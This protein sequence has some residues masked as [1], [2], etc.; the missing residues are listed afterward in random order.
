M[1]PDDLLPPL[2]Y[3]FQKELSKAYSSAKSPLSNIFSMPQAGATMMDPMISIGDTYSEKLIGYMTGPEARQLEEILD[4]LDARLDW[5]TLTRMFTVVPKSPITEGHNTMLEKII[6]LYTAYM[7]HD[8]RSPIPHIAGPPGTNKSTVVEQLAEL[9]GK[10]L[11]IINVARI[12]V[13]ELEGVQ[14]PIGHADLPDDYRLKLLTST[15]WT[16]L[17]DGDVVLLDEFMRG[18]PEVYNGLLDI[19][20]S[21]QVAGFQIPQVFF[22]SASNSVAAYDPAL[23][24]RLLHIPVPDI[25]KNK[26]ARN[27]VKD[28]FIQKLGLNPAIRDLPELESLIAIEVQPMY[29]VLDQFSGKGARG[30]S[31]LK[32]QSIRKLIGQALLRE[33]QSPALKEVIEMNN[34]LSMKEGKAQFVLLPNGK[35]PP[36]GYE[37]KARALVGNDKL[38]QIQ[39]ENIELNLQLIEMEIASNETTTPEGDE[40]DDIF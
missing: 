1:N 24:D 22:I 6:K 40:D 15:I 18:F 34:L 13:L 37:A 29:E 23:E 39:R 9:L 3:S 31:V 21:R 11:H 20:T 32:G 16:Q 5:N 30:P 33:M 12:N 4:K 14:M 8:V 26:T 28:A 10:K 17:K 35:T 36:Q 7:M 38:T 2:N 25:R 19:M 27:A